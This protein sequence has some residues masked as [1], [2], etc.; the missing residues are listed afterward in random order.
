MRHK[1]G[2]RECAESMVSIVNGTKEV[3]KAKTVCRKM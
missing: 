2:K 1:S 3:E